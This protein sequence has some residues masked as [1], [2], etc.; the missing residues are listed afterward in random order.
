M[1]NTIDASNYSALNFNLDSSQLM[2]EICKPLLRKDIGIIVFTYCRTFNNGTRLYL[3]SCPEWVKY[4]VENNFQDDIAHQ[5]SYAPDDNISYS[6]WS[7]F[8]EDSV[9]DAL[10]NHFRRWNGFSIY[11]RHAEYVDSFDFTAR[12]ES[13]QAVNYYIN[14]I[15]TL[16][17]LINDFKKASRDLIDPSDKK[18]LM[19]S[20]NWR[21]F[22]EIPKNSLLTSDKMK[23]FMS[24]TQIKI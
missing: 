2:G 9:Y 15:T 8:K 11:E 14:N 6:L 7:G 19:V 24:Q 21:P 3:C 12:L 1:S 20:K 22:N 10:R 18:K 4:Y 13:E 17:H 5:S 23:L 16:L